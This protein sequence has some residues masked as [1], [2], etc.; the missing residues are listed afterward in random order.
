MSRNSNSATERPVH[1]TA[2]RDHT[3]MTPIRKT[4]SLV[5]ILGFNLIAFADNPTTPSSNDA[6]NWLSGM[7]QAANTLSY[8]GNL[9]F[10][11]NGQVESFQLF[12]AIKEGVEHE[13]LISM[14]SPLREVVRNADSVVCYYPETKTAYVENK[15]SKHSL[16]L[17]FPED[18]ST[19]TLHYHFSLQ[20]QEYVAKR[21]AQTISITPRDDYR[22]ARRIWLDTQSK[23]PLKSELLDESGNDVE[24][25]VFTTLE[26]NP[27][28]PAHD[29]E[30]SIPTDSLKWET[31][32]REML[33]PSSLN[34]SLEGVPEGFRII[35]YS[36]MKRPGNPI[37][38]DHLLLS[39]GLSSVSIY[40]DES[41]S[42][43]LKSH[44]RKMGAFNAAT[45]KIGA[46]QVTVMGEVPE[47]TVSV[48]AEGLH[49]Q[50][51]SP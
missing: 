51:Q 36:R 14:N 42:D 31:K 4:L 9:S 45:R 39:D 37:P 19:L 26:L 30:A 46:F 13:R 48:I 38:L 2:S 10:S 28:L 15:P 8:K 44:P 7:R 1:Y 50:E 29:L 40:M 32:Q 5:L 47:R 24:Q 34:W 41:K 12:H 20:N 21:L 25:M 33:S 6:L 18:L 43:T 49:H 11:K 3:R 16:L 23:L 17:D 27:D 35:S 22:Y